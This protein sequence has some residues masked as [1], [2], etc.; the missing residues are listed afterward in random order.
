LWMAHSPVASLR[1]P[2]SWSGFR[3]WSKFAGDTRREN[4]PA[5]RR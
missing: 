4:R 3:V 5:V 1:A 2:R